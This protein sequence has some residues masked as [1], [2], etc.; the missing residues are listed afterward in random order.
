VRSV[1]AGRSACLASGCKPQARYVLVIPR[2]ALVNLADAAEA[3]RACSATCAGRRHGG[4]RRRISIGL[5]TVTIR[6]RGRPRTVFPHLHDAR[7]VPPPELAARLG[8]VRSRPGS[9]SRRQWRQT[10]RFMVLTGLPTSS[11][12]PSFAAPGPALLPPP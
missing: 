11:A 1:Y 4:S 2:Q 12:E 5:R 8:P 10:D 3:E 6:G 7:T 9:P